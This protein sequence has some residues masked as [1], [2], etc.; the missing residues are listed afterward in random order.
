MTEFKELDL[1]TMSIVD[2]DRLLLELWGKKEKARVKH[3]TYRREYEAK[4][5]AEDPEFRRRRNE[6]SVACNKKRYRDD[7]VFRAKKNA[8]SRESALNKQMEDALENIDLG[9]M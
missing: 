5:K 3:A 2:K 4:R 6:A 8:Q 7:P 1:K 9:I